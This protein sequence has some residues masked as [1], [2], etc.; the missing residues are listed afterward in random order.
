LKKSFPVIFG[1]GNLTLV[2]IYFMIVW[3]LATIAILIAKGL[4]RTVPRVYHILSGGR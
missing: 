2:I 3:I 4:E 1:H